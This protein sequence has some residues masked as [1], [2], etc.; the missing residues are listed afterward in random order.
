MY[1]VG[2]IAGRTVSAACKV[3]AIPSAG[4]GRQSCGIRPYGTVPQGSEPPHS[5]SADAGNH[6]R[7]LLLFL[8]M[9]P[10]PYLIFKAV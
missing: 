5:G 10:A 7:S 3:R 6:A 9:P 1:W 8:L 2:G 4:C